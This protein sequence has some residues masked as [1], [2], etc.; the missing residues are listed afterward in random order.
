MIMEVFKRFLIIIVVV[1]SFG[2]AIIA[3]QNGLLSARCAARCLTEHKD[4]LRGVGKKTHKSFFF[5]L[6]DL[7]RVDIL[8][9]WHI[10]LFS[11]LFLSFRR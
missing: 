3:G 6:R 11:T 7:L 4:S 1:L 10:V 9:L 2:V 5:I 8:R